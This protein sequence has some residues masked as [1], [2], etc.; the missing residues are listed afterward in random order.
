MWEEAVAQVAL[1]L[2]RTPYPGYQGKYFS[3]PPRNVVPKPVQKPHPPM[4][5]ACS[6]RPMIH[7]AARLGLRALTLAFL[8]RP[9]ARH[10]GAHFSQALQRR[11]PPNSQAVHPPPRLGAGFL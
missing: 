5:L 8:H 7:L 9:P 11:G 3:M 1:M 6:S 2:S 10:W 4:W